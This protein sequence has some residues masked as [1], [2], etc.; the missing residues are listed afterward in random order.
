MRRLTGLIVLVMAGAFAGAQQ[1]GQNK[2]AGAGDNFTLTVKV[3]LVVEAVVVKDKDGKPIQGLT[4]KDFALTEDGAPQSISFCEHQALAG[5]AEPL[6]VAAPGSEDI[7]IYKRLD[8][9]KR[10]ALG[11]PIKIPHVLPR[12]PNFFVAYQWTRDH[13]AAIQPGLVPTGA[14]RAGNLFGLLNAVGQPVT[15]YNPATGLPFAG[16]E[17]CIRDRLQ[18]LREGFQNFRIL[19]RSA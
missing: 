11:G 8:V 12:G 10:Q 5:H 4:A 1:I 15:V 9:Y 13:T 16:N 2:P 18:P 19:P 7:K 3:Q 17:M 6:P 14:E